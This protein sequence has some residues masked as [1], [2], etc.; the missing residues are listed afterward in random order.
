MSYLA[1]DLKLEKEEEVEVEAEAE[2]MF[3]E[4]NLTS[5]EK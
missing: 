1:S 3:L 5:L 4:V 2:A